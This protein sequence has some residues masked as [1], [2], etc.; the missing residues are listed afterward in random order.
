MALHFDSFETLDLLLIISP[1]KL[2]II[3][4]QHQ[5]FILLYLFLVTFLYGLFDWG[6]IKFGDYTYPPWA[7]GV[8]WLLA[9]SS[10]ITIPIGMG[11]AIYNAYKTT[12]YSPSGDQPT[13]RQVRF[14]FLSENTR[15]F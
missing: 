13:W 6:G 8:G 10:M 2:C 14:L 12:S 5:I 3:C 11:Y 15:F 1:S 7:E 9:L 4:G